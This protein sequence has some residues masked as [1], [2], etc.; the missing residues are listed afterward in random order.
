MLYVNGQ[1]KKKESPAV[2]F[3]P[4]SMSNSSVIVKT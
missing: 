3:F 4:V 2:Q 1:K